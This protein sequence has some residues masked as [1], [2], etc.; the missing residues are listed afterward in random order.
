MQITV[1]C[2][3]CKTRYQLDERM[4]GQRMRC[5]DPSCREVFVVMES[6]VPPPGAVGA[7]ANPD[8]IP[9]PMDED[10]PPPS[11]LGGVPLLSAEVVEE[12]P[13]PVRQGFDRLPV[14]QEITPWS[15]PP[16]V[17]NPNAPPAPPRKEKPA[18][19]KKEPASPAS[20]PVAEAPKEAVETMIAAHGAPLELPPGTWEPPPIR[21]GVDGFAPSSE[22]PPV[23]TSVSEPDDLV[24]TRSRRGAVITVS[25]LLGG[26][27]I[28]GVLAGVI[29][30]TLRSREEEQFQLALKD[31]EEGNYAKAAQAFRTL[32]Q[33]SQSTEKLPT[34]QF[35]A[36]WS[37]L[38]GAIES[39]TDPRVD[40]DR[41]KEFMASHGGNPQYKTRKG[42]VWRALQKLVEGFI[43]MGRRDRD[44]SAL[45]LAEAA[46][47]KAREVETPDVDAA[48]AQ[49][50]A[51]QA[52]GEVRTVIA[53]ARQLEALKQAGL[54]L[55]ELPKL[56]IEDI[57]RWWE[58]VARQ[59]F[60]KEQELLNLH[61]SL[62]GIVR[63]NVRYVPDQAAIPPS[64]PEPFEPSYQV[65]PSVG[66]DPP[67]ETKGRVIPALARAVLYGLAESNGE[68]VWTL[69]VGPDTTAL[70][71]RLDPTATTPEVFLVV[72]ANRQTLR[73]VD[74]QTGAP[75][76]E[77][78]LSAPCLGRPIVVE[79]I[80]YVPTYDGRVHE[81][82]ILQGNRLGYFELNQPLGVGG[83]WQPGTDL[84]F[85]PAD[86]QNIYIL[87]KKKKLCA[88]VLQTGHRSGSLRSEPLVVN[89]ADPRAGVDANAPVPGYLILAQADGLDHLKLR[90]YNLPVE[91]PDALPL[92]EERV[93]GWSWFL[94][95][96]DTEKL[97][98][99]T[100]AG[101]L[102]LYGVNQVRND[103][104]PIFPLLSEEKDAVSDAGRTSRAQV[105]HAEENDF[106]VLSR[107][108]LQKLHFDW[109]GQRLTGLWRTRQPLGSPLHAG[110]ID[111]G[112]ATLF[113]VSQSQQH[114]GCLATAVNSETGDI[115]WQRQLGLD[116]HCDPLAVGGVVLALDRG[117]SLFTFDPAK[118]PATPRAWQRGGRLVAGPLPEGPFGPLLVAAPDGKAV[119]EVACVGADGRRLVVRRY[120]VGKREVGPPLER[121]LTMPL[122][123]PPAVG[124]DFLLLPLKD[125][126]LVRMP[127]TGD[128]GRIVQ[129]WRASRAD[130]ESP[131]YV[132]LFDGTDSLHTDGLR[133][134]KWMRWAGEIG[135]EIETVVMDARIVAAPLVLP[136][137][138][139][140]NVERV[141]VADS[142]GTLSLL[143][144]A[145]L[146]VKRT[147]RLGSLHV[148][149]LFVRGPHIGCVVERKKLLWIDPEQ[150]EPAW[151]FTTPGDGIVGQPQLVGGVVL[152]ADLSGRFFALDPKTGKAIGKEH[153]LQS[154]TAPAATPAAFGDKHA[155]VPLTDGTVYLLPLD[156]LSTP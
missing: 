72:S 24:I 140:G 87:D 77:Y 145:K 121:E 147:W 110:Q 148:S 59:G 57:K 33:D 22:S 52:I 25:I 132:T 41:V 133:T 107:G 13:P 119:Y 26:L 58:P 34:Y 86:S 37:E 67:R 36:E 85:F 101:K 46:L 9:L 20:E 90:V 44:E 8:D 2:P 40:Y 39:G 23:E 69:R 88:G 27:L 54:A 84:L 94:P 155:F 96:H 134:I 156:A 45:A 68:P 5:P 3:R 14:A 47:E 103:D 48:D 21:R 143:E 123:G 138:N 153:R 56:T 80:A 92:R 108:E 51:T 126:D 152:V 105:V 130:A 116:S 38:R 78:P 102:A 117:G 76:W 139:P 11:H 73:A 114:R 4:R 6:S 62:E 129:T 7:A 16:P 136:K 112:A 74:A 99:A 81:I 141:L 79:R 93:R 127:L 53:R 82:E 154:G 1:Y 106:W 89:R 149:D 30:S 43:E 32:E 137:P 151:E 61:S 49:R 10:A 100:D 98:L 111:G 15:Q 35:F 29:Y 91:R 115:K 128:A 146:G 55:R 18:R 150:G 109:Y 65:A 113:V 66:P 120:D 71:V 122:A 17:R 142:A 118:L 70:P 28:L 131:G 75:R 104:K 63:S 95:Y 50:K 19:P 144:G 31:Y 125:G 12:E 60:D 42:D 83:A 97:A 124:D 135:R 64:P